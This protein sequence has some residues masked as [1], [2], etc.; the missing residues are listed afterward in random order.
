MKNKKGFTL[1]ELL[2]I[3]VI[4]AIIAVITVPIILNIIENSKKGAASDSAYGFKDAVNKAYVTK[5][6]GNSDYNITDGTYTVSDLKTQIGLSVSGKEPGENSWVTISKNNVTTGC[7]QYDDY[8]VEF[9]DGKVS[10]T[11]K[12]ECEGASSV[13]TI[14]SCPGCTLYVFSTDILFIGGS[15][16]S[17]ATEDYRTL[18]SHPFFLGMVPNSDTGKIERGFVCGIE[19]SVPFCLEGYD[20]TKFSDGTISGVLNTAFEG[21]NANSSDYQTECIGSDVRALTF[22]YG[23]VRIYD[24]N[25]S[26][27]SCS[28]GYDTSNLLICTE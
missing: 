2:A 22:S 21:C 26:S 13:P 27:I 4:L 16:P 6:S 7:L 9:T 19:Q 5:L 17:T 12:G 25:N 11:E 20:A 3:I 23:D 8:K 28:V 15:V 18:T 10:N 24:K 1:I 14:A